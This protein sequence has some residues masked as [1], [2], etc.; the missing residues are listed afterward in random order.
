MIFL[1]NASLDIALLLR[2]GKDCKFAGFPY[3]RVHV[4]Q[5]VGQD[6]D[7]IYASI[8]WVISDAGD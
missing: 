8:T 2:N 6:A 4:E 7:S 5:D 3:S 1:L